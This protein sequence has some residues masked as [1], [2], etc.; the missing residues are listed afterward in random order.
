[1]APQSVFRQERFQVIADAL[2]GTRQHAESRGNSCPYYALA[3]SMIGHFVPS[4]INHISSSRGEK[5]NMLSWYYLLARF[6]IDSRVGELMNEHDVVPMKIR[7]GQA[8]VKHRRVW[9]N[10]IAYRCVRAPCYHPQSGGQP[11]HPGKVPG[12]MELLYKYSTTVY[13]YMSPQA[14]H[15]YS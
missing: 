4:I 1:M 7:P 10:C 8:E 9:L 15:D 13:Y 11:G 5:E 2:R 12:S 3:Q 6:C 14:S